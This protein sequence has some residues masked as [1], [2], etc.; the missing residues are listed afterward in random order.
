M[1]KKIMY[2]L[3][4]LLFVLIFLLLVFVFVKINETKKAYNNLI[5]TAWIW[6]WDEFYSTKQTNFSGVVI[7][8]KMI[9]FNGNNIIFCIDEQVDLES[10]TGEIVGELEC[11]NYNYTFDKKNK[12][13]VDYNNEQMVYEFDYT[14]NGELILTYNG[15][16]FEFLSFYIAAKG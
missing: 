7:P 9:Y 10:K 3:G 16:G 14:E 15:D 12:I 1:K 5:S 13:T 8:N 4:V 6:S 11:T 2:V